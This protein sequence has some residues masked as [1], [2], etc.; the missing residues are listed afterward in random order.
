MVTKRWYR[1]NHKLGRA[2]LSSPLLRFQLLTIFVQPSFGSTVFDCPQPGRPVGQVA[3]ICCWRSS[4]RPRTL[5]PSRC[6]KMGRRGLHGIFWNFWRCFIFSLENK[7]RLFFPATCGRSAIFGCQPV[8][9]CGMRGERVVYGM[10]NLIRSK[11]WHRQ[12]SG[13]IVNLLKASLKTLYRGN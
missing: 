3:R 11:G 13:W 8:S 5:S 10:L 2:W 4:V 1:N 9:C 7:G 6:L 12:P